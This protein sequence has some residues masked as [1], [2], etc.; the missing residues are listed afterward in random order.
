MNSTDAPVLQTDGRAIAYTRYSIQAYAVA[1][2]KRVFA[3]WNTEQFEE[4][5]SLVRRV[6]CTV[7]VMYEPL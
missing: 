1:R 7:V 6:C 3:F 5:D 2:K 4:V